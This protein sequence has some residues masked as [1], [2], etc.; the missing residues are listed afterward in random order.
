MHEQ[1]Y[2][3]GITVAAMEA[4][5]LHKLLKVLLCVHSSEL[6]HDQANRYNTKS[7]ER[8]KVVCLHAKCCSMLKG[9]F[10]TVFWSMGEAYCMLCILHS[11]G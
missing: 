6:Y 7:I 5:A 1:V 10:H 2:G 3:Q 11:M 9:G 4:E 8:R